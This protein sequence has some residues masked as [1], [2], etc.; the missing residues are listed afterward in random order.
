MPSIP[1]GYPQSYADCERL[2]ARKSSKLGHNTYLCPGIDEHGAKFWAVRLYATNVVR[3]YPDGSVILDTGGWNTR[4]T[5]IRFRACGFY[6]SASE[7]HE[8][9]PCWRIK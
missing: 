3:F 4:T 2:G 8:L 1:K 6:L 7:I 9:G 5:Q